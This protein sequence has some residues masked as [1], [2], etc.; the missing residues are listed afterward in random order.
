MRPCLRTICRP[1]ILLSLLWLA[2]P[3]PAAEPDGSA[4][5]PPATDWGGHLR[6]IGSAAFFD[7]EAA[8]RTLDRE[9]YTDGQAELR[10]KNRLDGGARWALTT[11][12][13]LVALG[14]DARE[15]G[16]ALAAAGGLPE[17]L[18]P[19]SGV[20]DEQRLLDLTGVISESDRHLVYHRLDRLHLSFS[21]DWG[22]LRVGRQALTWGDGRIFNPM[23]LFDPFAP[24]AVQ[25][26]YKVGEDM[27]HLQ[28]PLGAGEGELLYL[29]RRDPDSG[30]LVEDQASYAAKL[31]LPIGGL[32]V[33][34]MGAR[35]YGDGVLGLG[36]SGYLGGALWRLNATYTQVTDGGGADDFIQAVA[37][38]DYAW[39]WG[40]RNVYGLLEVYYHQAGR[41]DDYGA[42][43]SDEVLVQRVARGE[44]FTLGRYYLAGQL[45]VE[46]HPLAQL[47]ATGIVN[48]VDPSGLVQPQLLW[49][50]APDWQAIIGGQWHW[51]ARGSEFGGYDIGGPDAERLVAPA[52]QVYLWV[53]YYF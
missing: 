5:W 31:H 8:Q 35:H 38:L 52:D 29:P 32:E 10:L 34:L 11:H 53:S 16:S 15:N 20:T 21:P 12:Y 3:V 51:G 25:R 30:E 23:D 43:L 24:T 9:S 50:L 41:T 17:G 39:I 18:L 1:L 27:A 48:P 47:H 37:N 26:D 2:G 22:R 36:G 46:L 4:T 45:Q 28:L 33:D 49:D 6:A 19:A 13:E 44:L 7:E 42:A 40:G 14:G